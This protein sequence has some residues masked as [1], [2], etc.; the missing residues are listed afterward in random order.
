MKKYLIVIPDLTLKGGVASYYYSIKNHLNDI[1]DFFIRSTPLRGIKRI[2][3][4]VTITVKFPYVILSSDYQYIVLNTSLSF[5][6]VA[7][8]IYFSIIAKTFR[9]K[10]IIFIRGWVDSY[11]DK[12]FFSIRIFLMKILLQCDTIIVLS[13]EFKDKLE[14]IGIKK[15]I[16][17][18]T[19]TVN[20]AFLS[21]KVNE[22]ILKKTGSFN[23]CYEIVF[24]ARVEIYKGIYE[25]ISAFVILKTK[26]PQ[27]R[28]KIIGSGSQ[29]ENIKNLIIE[30][31]ISDVSLLGYLDGQDKFLEL[32]NSD[33]YIFLS[34]SEGMP[35]SVLEAMACGLPVITSPVG[36]IKDFFI[37]GKMGYYCSFNPDEIA[38][39]IQ[40]LLNY[41]KL[42]LAMRVFNRNYA[43]NNFIS[44]KVAERLKKILLNV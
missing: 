38:A 35:N 33:L 25:I 22:A 3:F 29:Y 6:S 37:E 19:T 30:K 18:E 15:I 5:T 2:F 34:Y 21:D 27:L 8:D 23:S 32:A 36:G 20:E 9:K 16:I 44:S 4:F 14:K 28:L 26:L 11:F 10:T 42:R 13:N 7:R 41:N 12:N 39:L 31:E 1:C 17:V 24:L 40:N 43:M